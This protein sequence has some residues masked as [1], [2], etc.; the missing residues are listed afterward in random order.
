[1][2]PT[3]SLAKRANCVGLRDL[4]DKRGVEPRIFASAHIAARVADNTAIPNLVP[5]RIVDMPV[6]PQRRPL[7]EQLAVRGECR[8]HHIVSMLRGDALSGSARGGSRR[9]SFDR[10]SG[11]AVA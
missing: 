10:R 11:R 2:G 9:R 6:N 4:D 3:T 5:H 8:R 1:M 7:G